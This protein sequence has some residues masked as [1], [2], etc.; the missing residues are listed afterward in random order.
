MSENG[1]SKINNQLQLYAI[2]LIKQVERYRPNRSNPRIK[3]YAGKPANFMCYK[4]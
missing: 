3:R 4:P 1:Y 2:A